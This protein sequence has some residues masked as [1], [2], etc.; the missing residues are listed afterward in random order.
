MKTENYNMPNSYNQWYTELSQ[1]KMSE[2]ANS[3]VRTSEVAN[4]RRLLPK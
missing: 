2:N 1:T 4:Y 3:N